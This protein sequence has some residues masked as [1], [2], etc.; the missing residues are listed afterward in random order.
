MKYNIKKKIVIVGVT[1]VAG[2]VLLT[3]YWLVF[4]P[5]FSGSFAIEPPQSDIDLLEVQHA[6]NIFVVK[7]LK[8]IGSYDVTSDTSYKG[9]AVQ[10]SAQIIT[11]IK[12]VLRGVVTINQFD[13]SSNPQSYLLKPGTTYLVKSYNMGTGDNPWPIVGDA[14]LITNDPS[15][16]SEELSSIA[17]ENSEVVK[18]SEI[19]KLVES[20][21]KLDSTINFFKKIGE[22]WKLELLHLKQILIGRIVKGKT[23]YQTMIMHPIYLE[24]FSDDRVLVGASHNIFVGKVI[25]QISDKTNALLPQTQYEVQI[26][27]NIKGKLDGTVIVN[28]DGGYK[29]GVLYILDS[30]VLKQENDENYLLKP[31]LTYLLATRYSPKNSWYNL[32]SYSGSHTI[33]SQDKNL[34]MDQLQILVKN[35]ERVTGLKDAYP[36]EI[37]SDS[38]IKNGGT[39]N[40]Y[41]SLNKK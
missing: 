10:F 3:A 38:D 23:G 33:I 36:Q 19:I 29:N 13:Y 7:I 2:F 28:Q 1:I 9:S 25:R 40:N 15:L 4:P 17:K 24:D 41:N 30:D 12:G 39:L 11:N 5:S 6:Q 37:L 32:N 35:N 22:V 31:G 34:S 26:I 20:N 18:V 14:T 21:S 16:N 27:S 8:Q